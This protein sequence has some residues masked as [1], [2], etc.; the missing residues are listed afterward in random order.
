MH[1]EMS[2]I[3]I[4]PLKKAFAKLKKFSQHLDTEQEK[5][6][7][8]QA[9]EYSFELSWKTMKKFLNTRGREAN[10]PREVFRYAALEGFIQDAELWFDFLVKRNLTVHTYE[11]EESEQVIAILPLFVNEVERLIAL[12]ET[13]SC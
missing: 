4:D 11:E 12:L 8:I 2:I 6:G 5:A 1:T 9:F 3:N 10:S 7:A 13:L